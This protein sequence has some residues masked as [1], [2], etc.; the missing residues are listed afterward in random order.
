MLALV[1]LAVSCS[2]SGGGPAFVAPGLRPVRDIGRTLGVP[3][4]SV[5]LGEAFL[6]GLGEEEA[7]LRRRKGFPGG[8]QPTIPVA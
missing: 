7:P 5:C 3:R 4:W 1:V 6:R 8:G 2:A